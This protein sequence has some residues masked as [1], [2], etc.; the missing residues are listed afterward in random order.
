VTRIIAG[1]AKGRRLV[2]PR[3]QATRPTAS[4]VKQTLFDILA[5]RLP[6]SRFLDLCAGTG[7]V[8][9]EAL[10]RGAAEVV[11]VERDARVAALMRVNAVALSEGAGRVDVRRSDCLRA[12]RDL[13][14]EGCRFDLVFLDPPYESELYE[15]ALEALGSL[16]LLEASGQV[17]AE[18]FHKRPLPETI[19]ALVHHRSVRVGDHRLSFYRRA[20]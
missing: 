7:A 16:D 2:A 3:G 19:G 9:L 13:A 10:S 6:G 8:G 4:R 12:L 18:H 17:V 20:R 1:R 11:L 15:A 5:P 14:R